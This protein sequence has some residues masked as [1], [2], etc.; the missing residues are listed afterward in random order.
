MH[1]NLAREI[2]EEGV[3]LLKNEGILPF[4]KS[5]GV[6]VLGER[7]RFTLL[8]GGGS[9]EVYT[10]DF[11]SVYQGMAKMSE[12]G[13]FR[14]I[15]ENDDYSEWEKLIPSL[16]EN[17]AAVYTVSLFSTEGEDILPE[18]FGLSEKDREV[19][20]SLEKSR[21]KGVVVILNT[22]S[23]FR[24]ADLL[25]YKKIKA[26]VLS[27]Y[28]G[29]RGGEA[30]AEI[31]SGRISPSG[32][33]PDTLAASERDYPSDDGFYEETDIRYNEGIFVGYRYFE[34]NAET[35]K[36]VIYPFGYGL[37]Y[38]DFSINLESAEYD[39]DA[40]K[41]VLR[42]KVKNAG[43]R[44]G[45]EVVQA[46]YSSPEVSGEP[47]LCLVAFAKTGV[48]GAGE[49]ETLSLSFKAEDMKRFDETSG[50]FALDKGEYGIFIGKNVRETEKVFVWKN[51]ERRTVGKICEEE[52][53]IADYS[54]IAG[55]KARKLSDVRE[56]GVTLRDFVRGFTDEELVSFCQAQPP[57]YASG[58]AGYGNDKKRGI[59]NV[60]TADGPAGVRRS[61]ETTY[62]PCATLIA[63]TWNV[64]LAEREG[65]AIA[66]EALA[67][68]TDVMLA[69]GVNIHRHPLCGRNFEYYSED[70]RLAGETGAAFINGIQ[71]KGV[72]ACVKHFVANNKEN[73]RHFSNSIVGE[74]A[75]REIYYR[76]FEIVLRLESLLFAI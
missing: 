74:R 62:F 34:Q 38:T 69:P 39:K 6:L 21:V 35:K 13:D 8:G 71:S 15:N 48:I 19:L 65:K 45:K 12:K 3:V 63:A 7:S 51:E 40:D 61:V 43:K 25:G 58:T 72:G 5:D 44:S 60:Q 75:W 56:G 54:Y 14:L 26:V 27:Y 10:T 23:F 73:N 28:G 76:V 2:A 67:L 33:L 9:S 57:A 16:T 64:S 37:S 66:K 47:P 18:N 22:P 4:K 11:T 31:L 50:S 70:P 52:N 17:D 1:P 29:M 32:R 59:P 30:V 68:K 42:V 55:G 41:I 53:E 20:S 24:V 49:E 46:Y 36:K